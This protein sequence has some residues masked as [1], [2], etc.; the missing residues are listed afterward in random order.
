MSE[1]LGLSKNRLNRFHILGGMI[2]ITMLYQT[3]TEEQQHSSAI[4]MLARDLG[5]AEDSIRPFYENE[6]RTLQEQAEIRTFLS[7]LV[8][9]RVKKKI[10]NGLAYIP[11]SDYLSRLTKQHKA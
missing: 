3:E 10:D 6:L 7:I 5:I 8:S 1:P 2:V 4:D 9:R 11:S